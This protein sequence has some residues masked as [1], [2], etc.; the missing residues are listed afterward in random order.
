MHGGNAQLNSPC[1]LCV[2]GVHVACP[3]GL[4]APRALHCR[5]QAGESARSCTV[6]LAR[7][8]D[9][10]AGQSL[11]EVFC[12]VYDKTH[13]TPAVT[14][15]QAVLLNPSRVAQRPG[16]AAAFVPSFLDPVQPPFAAAEAA[17]NATSS[18]SPAAPL[19]DVT[20]SPSTPP[21]GNKNKSEPSPKAAGLN[22]G[23]G[24]RHS[25]AYSSLPP[26]REYEMPFTTDRVVLEISG[27][28]ADLTV[29]DLPGAWLST[30]DLASWLSINVDTCESPVDAW[31]AF[32]LA[33][34][35]RRRSTDGPT[36]LRCGACGR[37]RRYLWL[38]RELLG[39]AMPAAG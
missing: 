35:V 13:I 26:A 30:G 14:A 17:G 21:K 31:L 1:R 2:D 18:D 16:G 10:A 38:T 36:G 22:A 12:K 25:K 15:A 24:V 32:L 9:Q 20:A 34:C 3:H 7:S 4:A 19:P 23:S 5:A 33:G 6:K 39:L 28:D 27:A 11:E 8:L 37:R 29:V